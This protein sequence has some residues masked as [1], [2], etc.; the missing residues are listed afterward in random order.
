MIQKPNEKTLLRRSDRLIVVSN[1]I[2]FFRIPSE[3]LA[4]AQA[5]GFYRPRDR[6]LTIVGN[7]DHLFEIPLTDAA[8]AAKDGYRDLLSFQPHI[9][10]PT[11]AV[12]LTDH[13]DPRP[14]TKTAVH[15]PPITAPQSFAT[16]RVDSDVRLLDVF[17]DLSQA[18]QQEEQERIEKE[19]ALAEAEGWR[20]HL[21]AWKFWIEDRR[22]EISRQLGGSGVSLLIHVA[23][24]LL[25]ASLALVSE[26]K[27]QMFLA[28]SMVDRTEVVQ[29]VII[30]PLPTEIAE[31]TEDTQPEAPAEAQE[32]ASEMPD[33]APDFLAG[34][35]GDAVKPPEFPAAKANNGEAKPIKRPT[36]FGSKFSA[37]NYVFVIDNSNSMTKGRFETALNE[38]M[39]TINQLT[40]KQRFYIIFY[41]DTAYPMMH[42]NP[43]KDLV[44]A[45]NQNKYQ[46]FRWLETVELCLKTNGKK[47]LQAAFDLE[48]DVI[49]VLGDGAFTDGTA[50]AF[51]KKPHPRIVLHTRGMEVKEKDA[52]SFRKLAEINRGTYMDVGVSPQGALMAKQAPRRRNNTR[53]P[54]WGL[55]LPQKKN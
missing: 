14:S 13:T 27:E 49:Y 34:V 37:I 42:P 30:E 53:G 21:L 35:S 16:N 32:L 28:A 5:D 50:E 54:V 3:D 38:L 24:I 55:E 29:D 51:S 9:Q 1:G 40:P 36:I 26:E 25:L 41:S 33:S 52:R 20:R 43:V 10:T 22:S 7:G 2:E 11:A 6:G 39:I 46:L 8:A 44:P 4:A 45:T 23:L 18:N 12:A 48:P 47:A 19:L 17:E 15:P 31:P